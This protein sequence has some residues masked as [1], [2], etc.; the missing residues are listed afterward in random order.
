VLAA[1]NRLMGLHTSRPGS[2]SLPSLECPAEGPC[3]EITYPLYSNSL[4]NTVKTTDV[5]PGSS[6]QKY[7]FSDSN[8]VSYDCNIASKS[9]VLTSVSRGCKQAE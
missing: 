9:A 3:Q 5:S 1:V 7:S 4:T 6:S 8:G 2:N